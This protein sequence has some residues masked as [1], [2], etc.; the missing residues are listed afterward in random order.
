MQHILEQDTEHNSCRWS[1]LGANNDG[2]T[3]AMKFIERLKAGETE[4]DIY[5][6][7]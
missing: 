2:A 6:D 1:C 5:I 7:S 4:T 3:T